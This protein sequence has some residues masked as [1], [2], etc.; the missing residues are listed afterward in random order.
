MRWMRRSG[1]GRDRCPFRAGRTAIA[2]P[3]DSDNCSMHPTKAG[4]DDLVDALL[5]ASRA[6]VGLAAR[7]LADLDAEVTLPQYR[8]LVVLASRGPQRMVDISTELRVNPST[9]TRMCDRLGRKG[10]ARRYRTA[11]DRRAVRLTLTPAGR[12]L[13]EEVTTRRRTDLTR[14]V[15]DMPDQHRTP[16]I[17]ALRLRHRRRRGPRTGVVARLG[18][19]RRGHPTGMTTTM[20]RPGHHSRSLM[21]DP[22]V[23]PGGRANTDGQP[24]AGHPGRRERPGRARYGARS[25]G[26]AHRVCSSVARSD[27]PGAPLERDL[28]EVADR[29]GPVR[30]RWERGGAVPLCGGDPCAPPRVAGPVGASCWSR[31][32]RRRCCG[33][34][35]PRAGPAQHPHHQ[36]P[37]RHDGPTARPRRTRAWV[38]SRWF[39]SALAA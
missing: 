17:A 18:P 33:H 27:G 19:D 4:R 20:R 38:A 37:R 10:L 6:M 8:A 25:P 12:R 29:R 34:N 23:T 13:V 39:R 5:S 30:R 2:D 16:V 1:T 3:A 24:R 15:A 35:V 14:I 22:S 31:R 21:L 7:S 26:S 9:G 28:H 32:T 36:F 11:G